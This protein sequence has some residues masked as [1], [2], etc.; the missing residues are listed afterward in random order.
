[1]LDESIP[2]PPP[3][4]LTEMQTKIKQDFLKTASQM[5]EE[6]EQVF[7]Y[8][9]KE[10]I[11]ILKEHL[12]QLEENEE[13]FNKEIADYISDLKQYEQFL[14]KVSAANTKIKSEDLKFLKH[15]T[16]FKG[17]LSC[18]IFH[19]ENKNTKK[20][21]I[22]YL[23]NM[24]I[25]ATFLN[26]SLNQRSID[27]IS[28]KLSSLFKHETTQEITLLNK[29]PPSMGG[30]ENVF[31][32]ILSNPAITEMATELS[33]DLQ[34]ENIDPMSLISSLMSGKP[35]NKMSKL[36]NQMTSKIEEKINNGEIDK[37]KLEKDAM[38]M[39]N[40]INDPA[41]ISLLPKSN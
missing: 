5:I 39:L 8:I 23:H 2:Q 9:P 40:V 32:S 1:M 21:I 28:N 6:F 10:T 11:G 27:D 25:C 22:N 15:I 17:K 36:M 16:L 13:D 4:I 20:T 41:I 7:S 30:L 3:L 38:S 31:G 18:K 34:N 26:I 37:A 12:K 19:G 29:K 33:K 14:T 24:Y 35:D